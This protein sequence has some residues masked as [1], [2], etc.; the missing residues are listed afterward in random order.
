MTTTLAHDIDDVKHYFIKCMTT[1]E[2]KK[3]PLTPA[4][5]GIQGIFALEDVSQKRIEVR[6]LSHK[7][8]GQGEESFS[9]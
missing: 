6:L 1:F 8:L 9:Q 5:Q 7:L 4:T 3:W 2:T